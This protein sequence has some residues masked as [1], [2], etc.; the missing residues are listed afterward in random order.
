MQITRFLLKIFFILE[1]L[2]RFSMSLN[3]TFYNNSSTVSPVLPTG[4][5]DGRTVAQTHL[6]KPT[7]ALRYLSSA[8]KGR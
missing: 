7:V 1:F 8:S 3:L 4:Q 2:D 6:T 5:T